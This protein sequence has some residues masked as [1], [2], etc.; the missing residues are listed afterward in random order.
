MKYDNEKGLS[1][2]S[3]KKQ[4]ALFAPINFDLGN[5]WSPE[6]LSSPYNWMSPVA[7]EVNLDNED[8]Q[9]G[10]QSIHLGFMTPVKAKI[11]RP[12]SVSGSP[13]I[14]DTLPTDSGTE[15]IDP[16][17]PLIK[18]RSD[19]PKKQ[20][21]QG[22][23]PISSLLDR[24]S[25]FEYNRAYPRIRYRVQLEDN[26]G[27]HL[28]HL[29]DHEF[30]N[31]VNNLV[32]KD[33]PKSVADELARMLQSDL[34]SFEKIQKTAD[35]LSRLFGLSQEAMID[36]AQ[37][38]H[39][40][41]RQNRPPASFKKFVADFRSEI[42][43]LREDVLAPGFRF[44]PRIL[45]LSV[46]N[47]VRPFLRKLDLQS[48]E[49]SR[50]AFS[51]DSENLEALLL[52]GSGSSEVEEFCLLGG[53]LEYW[54]SLTSGIHPD[55]AQFLMAHYCDKEAHCISQNSYPFY[56]ACA[57]YAFQC[58]LTKMA[59]RLIDILEYRLSDFT[60]K[61]LSEALCVLW[62]PGFNTR[63]MKDRDFR[64][65]DY[66]SGR[67]DVYQFLAGDHS[68]SSVA[69]KVR[70]TE[71]R[72][73]T[74]EVAAI[75]EGE[76]R[77]RQ[78]FLLDIQKKSFSELMETLFHSYGRLVVDFY[79]FVNFYNL[80]KAQQFVFSALS[81]VK[82]IEESPFVKSYRCG[83]DELGIAWQELNQVY[84][85]YF[86]ISEAFVSELHRFNSIPSVYWVLDD[87]HHCFREFFDP[88]HKIEP[89]PY[90]KDNRKFDEDWLIALLTKM[91]LEDNSERDNQATSKLSHLLTQFKD[92][93][94]TV[95]N[96]CEQFR[97]TNQERQDR[98][99]TLNG[100][101]SVSDQLVTASL[102]VLRSRIAAV[103]QKAEN[104]QVMLSGGQCK[105]V[106]G[107]KLITSGLI[108][109][110]NE[111]IVKIGESQ[112]DFSPGISP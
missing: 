74:V 26:F 1:G 45:N 47:I 87:F 34:P 28:A 12:R 109:R 64:A 25:H 27:A 58:D 41:P 70:A 72:Q 5:L 38:A 85:Y 68:P 88:E 8:S 24:L 36:P 91:S 97:N 63:E 42:L 55:I 43:V 79:D 7:V 14:S 106:R 76:P 105:D 103:S 44:V 112:V 86:N 108:D 78:S 75:S 35:G 50:V 40:H 62:D 48:D 107:Q 92:G 84:T 101:R 29:I 52:A 110:L 81:K 95:Y 2:N 67:G 65:L 98:L 23:R 18:R 33:R 73:I 96:A 100:T 77:P 69:E 60:Y 19:T 80:A 53:M 4:P 20:R 99:D 102:P 61:N 93:L 15:N 9:C 111:V 56:L 82:S 83:L 17:T 30:Y 66:L 32:L 31:G 59:L 54:A 16:D 13:A 89:Y 46:E 51:Q 104:L 6:K 39:I 71:D 90:P 10:D 49:T 57:M 11:K 22:H 94:E 21:S 3:P 37:A